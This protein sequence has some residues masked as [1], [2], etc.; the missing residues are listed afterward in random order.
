MLFSSETNQFDIYIVDEVFDNEVRLKKAKVGGP[1]KPMV[2]TYETISKHQLFLNRK[3][4][5]RKGF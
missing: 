4:F 3:W 1:G 2:Y 5:T